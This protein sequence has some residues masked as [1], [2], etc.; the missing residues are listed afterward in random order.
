MEDKE[1]EEGDWRG[2]SKG[3]A[4]TEL[5]AED[6]VGRLRFS[7]TRLGTAVDDILRR[8]SK[9][10]LPFYYKNRM[11]L[12]LK[13]AQL[14]VLFWSSTRTTWGFGVAQSASQIDL[15]EAK[16]PVSSISQRESR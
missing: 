11:N 7:A 3:E 13:L 10:I 6:S 4:E 1:V 2:L 15:E 8:G 5:T 16:T 9:S 14:K 12:S